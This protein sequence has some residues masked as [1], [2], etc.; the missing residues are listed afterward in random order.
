M[1]IFGIAALACV[2]CVTV[3]LVKKYAPEYAVMVEAAG[4]AAVL[5]FSVSQLSEVFG[6]LGRAAESAGASAEYTS[7]LFKA[8]GISVVGALA[9]DVCK[10]GGSSALSTAV[11]MFSKAAILVLALPMIKAV[12]ALAAAYL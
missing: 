6:Q 9:S 1:D 7:L 11:D 4:I 5:F 10:D 8:L 12:F 3:A 2:G